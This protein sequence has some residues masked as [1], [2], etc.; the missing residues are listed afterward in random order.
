VAWIAAV[1]SVIES[2]VAPRAL[3]EQTR[4]AVGRR[5]APVCFVHAGRELSDAGVAEAADAPAFVDCAWLAAE[6]AG[7]ATATVIA[8]FVNKRRINELLLAFIR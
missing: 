4:R 7:I 8:A 1:L 2:P 3:A 6:G 5:R